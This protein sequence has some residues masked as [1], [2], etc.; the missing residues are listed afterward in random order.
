LA[1][2]RKANYG[3]MRRQAKCWEAWVT[4]KKLD[5][6]MGGK[7]AA[8]KFMDLCQQ[9][10][11]EA[12]NAQKHPKQVCPQ[13]SGRG[14]ISVE[15]TPGY[16]VL[17]PCDCQKPILYSKRQK[18]ANIPLEYRDFRLDLQ[19]FKLNS[20]ESLQRF[21]LNRAVEATRS[22]RDTLLQTY[23]A[24]GTVRGCTGIALY[25]P[26]GVG[27]T[28]IACSLLN[29]LIEGGLHDV[30]Q[31]NYNE[32]FGRIKRTY[33][34]SSPDGATL[35]FLNRLGSVGVLMIDDFMDTVAGKLEWEIEMINAIIN[36][37]YLRGLPIILTANRW[38]TQA[39][40]NTAKRKGAL[41]ALGEENPFEKP[42]HHAS[43]ELRSERK[44]SEAKRNSGKEQEGSLIEDPQW[45]MS[46]RAWSRLQVLCTPLMM[47]G[48]DYRKTQGKRQAMLVERDMQKRGVKGSIRDQI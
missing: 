6:A 26:F 45:R 1:G 10:A 2:F 32:L 41:E 18:E 15:K 42:S 14:F 30:Y 3:K 7:E 37:R 17:T 35:D 31:I 11:E 29:E 8:K 19:G 48:R 46:R 20:S 44:S 34:K 43:K 9:R 23:K 33:D 4:F 28:R 21:S 40:D 24:N 16:P 25:G 27:K 36:P 38:Y 5:E 12:R 13:C 39:K 47:E 22:V